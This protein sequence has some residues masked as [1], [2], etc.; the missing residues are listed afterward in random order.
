MGTLLVLALLA[1]SGSVVGNSGQRQKMAPL[2]DV[3]TVSK[4]EVYAQFLE[5]H[6]GITGHQRA[7]SH[8]QEGEVPTH[9]PANMR[10]PVRLDDDI[11]P[12]LSTADVIDFDQGVR[13]SVIVL[14]VGYDQEICNDIGDNCQ[15]SALSKAFRASGDMLETAF[16]PYN[17]V[18]IDI[19]NLTR[20]WLDEQRKRQES[21]SQALLR[22]LSE[23]G[24]TIDRKHG[25]IGAL[26]Y[27][28][29]GFGEGR[30]G[31]TL[32]GQ[33]MNLV[34]AARRAQLVENGAI[35]AIACSV[36][37]KLNL[38]RDHMDGYRVFA[39]EEYIEWLENGH[40]RRA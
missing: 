19:K 37:K 6:I 1:A 35:V 3:I 23:V 13:Q 9:D 33:S 8:P 20:L 16:A 2:A 31:P 5:R 28:G 14:I 4:T 39:T 22:E 12:L 32:T 38:H 25:R 34:D 24:D 30:V 10:T 7:Q 40:V 18:R 27:V 29:H 26:I 21:H 11:D 17:V 36:A 15:D